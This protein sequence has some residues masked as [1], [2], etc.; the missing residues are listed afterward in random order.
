MLLQDGIDA[1]DAREDL[2][3]PPSR[4]QLSASCHTEPVKTCERT[5]AI[6]QLHPCSPLW[7]PVLL[8]KHLFDP[9]THSNIGL[10]IGSS[11]G[12]SC[13]GAEGVF[14]AFSGNK[15][16]APTGAAPTG[17]ASAAGAPPASTAPPQQL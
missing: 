11:D 13:A 8:S 5:H 9:F 17:A 7:A 16:A 12:S 15:A 3:L 1:K 10:V 2:T 4:L 14:N 6:P